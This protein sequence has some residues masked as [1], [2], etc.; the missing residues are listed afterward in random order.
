[1]SMLLGIFLLFFFVVALFMLFGAF[2]QDAITIKP[3]VVNYG[4]NFAEV[5]V[6]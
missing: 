1:M 4:D 5:M 3:V 2:G 6:W